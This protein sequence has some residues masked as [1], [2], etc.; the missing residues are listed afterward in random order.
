MKK[1][2]LILAEPIFRSIQGEGPKIGTPSI[3]LRLAGCNLSCDFCDSR[4]T[5]LP[6]FKNTW[7]NTEIQNVVNSILKVKKEEKNLIITGG[8]PLLQKNSLIELISLIKKHF[9]SIEIETNGT[10]RP[11]GLLK[12]GSFF[13]VS[14]KLSNSG[15]EV[16]A[17]LNKSLYSFAIYD[18]SIFKFV[19]ESEEDIKEVFK[20]I[21]KFSIKKDK[22]Y[23]MP[24]SSSR[25]ELEEKAKTVLNLSLK[26]GLNYS[27]RLHL[28]FDIK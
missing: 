6:E 21:E 16:E 28:R 27:D 9:T 24:K 3:F 25:K 17:R 14:P 11:D 10:I 7:I 19:V 23:L 1:S 13:N 15:M 26:Y 12:F 22:V 4:F 2:T 18:K 5:F 20:I 8:E